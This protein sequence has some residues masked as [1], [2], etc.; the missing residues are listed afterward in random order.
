M[1]ACSGCRV[2][3]QPQ[4]L[5]A[6]VFVV[7]AKCQEAVDQAVREEFGWKPDHDAIYDAGIDPETG[8]HK[9]SGLLRLPGKGKKNKNL[10]KMVERS[11]L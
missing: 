2:L 4:G 10:W 7:C 1:R 9:D 11:E 5:R 8:R 3:F 6:H